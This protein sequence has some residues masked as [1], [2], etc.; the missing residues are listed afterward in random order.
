MPEE[1]IRQ[2]YAGYRE[3]EIYPESVLF[4]DYTRQNFSTFP[5]PYYVDLRKRCRTC[6]QLFLFFAQEQRHWYETLGFYIDVDC[7]FCPSCR[8]DN[9]ALRRSRARYSELVT[10]VDLTRD[11]LKAL[12]DDGASLLAHGLLRDLGRVARIK[13]MAL[14]QLPQ[15]KGT[16]TLVRAIRDAREAQG[17]QK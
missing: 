6:K 11:E 7:A 2:S 1:D 13:N 14:R 3:A 9:Q 15:Y 5:R 16:Q 17:R 4:A 12:V 8:R 10:K